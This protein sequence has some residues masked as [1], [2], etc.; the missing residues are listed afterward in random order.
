VPSDPTLANIESL[1]D[2][3]QPFAFYFVRM[4]R[5]HG[6]P[7]VI[8]S[9]R[10]EVAIADRYGQVA[11]NSAH[12]QGLAFDVQVLGY[13]VDDLPWAWW[14]SMGEFWEA[15]GGRWGGRFTMPDVNHFDTGP[16]YA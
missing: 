8:I 13:R 11:A 4:A 7:L 15:L 6:I 1:D 10:R 9:G 5:A 14:L 12:L 2:R 3:L 16:I